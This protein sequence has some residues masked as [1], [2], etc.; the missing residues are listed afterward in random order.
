MSE[1]YRVDEA[2]ANR[3]ERREASHR[4]HIQ[5]LGKTWNTVGLSHFRSLAIVSAWAMARLD[6]HR[7]YRVLDTKESTK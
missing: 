3:R 6:N 2:R 4:Y 7:N 5:R 1:I